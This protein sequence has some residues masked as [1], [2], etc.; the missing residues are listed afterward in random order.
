MSIV[1][2]EHSCYYQI[3]Q[4][5][6][7]LCQP[8]NPQHACSDHPYVKVLPFS[9]MISEKRLRCFIYIF[10]KIKLASL[11]TKNTKNKKRRLQILYTSQKTDKKTKNFPPVLWATSQ[12][13]YQSIKLSL[14]VG[15]ICSLSYD[16]VKLENLYAGVVEEVLRYFSSVKVPLQRCKN[17][18][19]QVPKLCN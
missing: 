7:Y 17:T 19:F 1:I 6:L 12:V 14:G 4:S 5:Q 16:V 10:S 8:N 2:I 18:P 11:G 15:L 13:T 3:M 9:F